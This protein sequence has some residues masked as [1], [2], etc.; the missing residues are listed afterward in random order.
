VSDAIIKVSS[1]SLRTSLRM[2][3]RVAA[4]SIAAFFSVSQPASVVIAKT[5][6]QAR[7]RSEIL[8]HDYRKVRSNV[9]ALNPAEPSIHSPAF[10]GPFGLNAVSVTSGELLTK[11]NGVEA[12]I[13]AE[14]EILTRCRDTLELCPT[15]ARNF[16]AI[17]AEGRAHT[18]RA[19]IGVINRAI[20]LAI[21]PMS[22]L[23]QWGAPDHWSAPLAT[24]TTGRGDCED[25]A[26][27]KYVALK[28][29]GVT[30]DDVRL[31]IVH[32]LIVVEDHAVVAARTD[33]GWIILD[34]RWLALVRDGEMRH[35]TPLFAL[36]R[37]G[38]KQFVPMTIASRATA[39]G[40][41]TAS[42]RVLLG[43]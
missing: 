34:N 8:Y 42:A 32:D 41:S 33:G 2:F 5:Q 17:I 31:V 22:D 20:N 25:Y 36:D 15:A 13:R 4:C 28:A 39:P 7:D 14:H 19:R 18:G 21:R 29:A 10:A 9:A 3:G 26:I 24:L 30:E 37:R 35:V 23:A 38:V 11:W 27:A 16:L 6:S 1:F 12:D 40:E 43:L